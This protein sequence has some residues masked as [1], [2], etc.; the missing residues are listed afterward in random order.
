MRKI[1]LFVLPFACSVITLI[2]ANST[3]LSAQ[4]L[5][6][7]FGIYLVENGE[8]VLS[9]SDF[10]GFYRKTQ[11]IKLNE[12]GIKKWN[13]Y[14][15]YDSSRGYKHRVLGG[16]FKKQFV[17]KIGSEEIYRGHFWSWASSRS[18]DGIVI[19]D[20]FP[21]NSR[22]DRLK[23]RFGYPESIPSGLGDPREDT[24]IIDYFSKKGLLR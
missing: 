5:T 16:L 12:T 23:I 22:F 11:E 7:G 17:V 13:S 6:S 10:V 3:S 8:L 19:L 2:V 9:D 4:T 1:Y 14:V 15:A 24:K 21:L 20:V 18:N